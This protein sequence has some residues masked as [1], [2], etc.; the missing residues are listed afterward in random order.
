MYYV[1]VFGE[2]SDVL[3]RPLGHRRT[4]SHG[5][6]P[7]AAPIIPGDTKGTHIDALLMHRMTTAPGNLD[8]GRNR[9][10]PTNGNVVR[11]VSWA[12]EQYAGSGSAWTPK[13][14]SCKSC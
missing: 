4:G 12:A 2:L 10:V 11:G 13:H 1:Y 14:G 7:V 6:P 3:C 5:N 8:D 9:F